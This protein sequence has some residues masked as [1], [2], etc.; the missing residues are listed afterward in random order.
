LD[1]AAALIAVTITGRDASRVNAADA[2][3]RYDFVRDGGHWKIDNIRGT[4]DGKQW[5]LRGMLSE[6]L[7]S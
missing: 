4:E 3:I 2:V 6:S 7:K 1:V 5:S